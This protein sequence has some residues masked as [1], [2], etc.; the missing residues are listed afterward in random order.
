MRLSLLPRRL[1]LRALPPRI[2]SGIYELP[3]RCPDC[4]ARI[5]RPLCTVPI[6]AEYVCGH[7]FIWTEEGYEITA[8]R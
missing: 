6:G 7:R 3:S 2:G 5:R 4:Q 8:P 1:P